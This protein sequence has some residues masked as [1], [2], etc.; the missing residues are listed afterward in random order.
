[1]VFQM[2]ND[3][4]ETDFMLETGF[5]N[6]ESF[7]SAWN[8]NAND[9]LKRKEHISV[10]G[11][12]IGEEEV[13]FLNIECD[14]DG[15]SIRWRDIGKGISLEYTHLTIAPRGQLDIRPIYSMVKKH[16]NLPKLGKISVANLKNVV[17]C[18]VMYYGGWET[19]LAYVPNI[20]NRTEYT[21]ELL[22]NITAANL[23]NFR[24]EFQK[25]LHGLLDKNVASD[26]LAKNN[27]MNLKKM[28]VLPA[29]R[30]IIL[31]VFQSSLEATDSVV[32]GMVPLLFSFRF[33]EKC[34]T[35]LLL[36]ILDESGVEDICVHV[37]IDIRNEF[38]DVLWCR[39]GVNAVVGNRGQI[40]SALS[41]FEC[42]NF[43]SNVDDR[44][45][46]VSKQL[47]EVCRFPEH[48]RFVQLYANTPHRRATL[49]PHS[50]SASILFAEGL[51]REPSYARLKRNTEEYIDEITNNF[52][53]LRGSTCRM[54]F[55]IALPVVVN[56]VFGT[57]YI[58]KDNLLQLL[59]DEPMIVPFE[60]SGN[61]FGCIRKVGIH[62]CAS[63][64]HLYRTRCRTGNSDAVWEAYQCELAVE[65]LLWGN[66]FCAKSRIYSVNLGVGL[67]YPSRCLTDQRG[68]LCLEESSACCIDEDTTPKLNIYTQNVTVQRQ[69][70]RVFGF[71][72]YTQAGSSVLGQ[73]LM[74][75]LIRDLY[76]VG[77]V[78]FRVEYFFLMLKKS[79]GNGNK[80]I[81]GGITIE[82]LAHK[83]A[84]CKKC[85]WPM[86]FA[87]L[88]KLLSNNFEKLKELCVE[89]VHALQLGYFPAV[90]ES[91]TSKHGGLNWNYMYG[92][93]VLMDNDTR[94]D[95]FETEASSIHTSVLC[96][97]EKW[98]ICH[99]SQYEQNVFP[100]I[101][102][103]L[104]KI[105]EKNLTREDKVVVLAFV[106]AVA[107]LMNDR[108][109][110]YS[111]LSRLEKKMP[112]T[113]FMLKMLEVQC[114]FLYG[115]VNTFRLHRLHPSIPYRLENRKA[116]SLLP[117]NE[118]QQDV[119]VDHV[120]DDNELGGMSAVDDED[121]GDQVE[122]VS[123]RHLPTSSNR[124][125]WSLGEVQILKEVAGEIRGT[126]VEQYKSYQEKCRCKGIPDRTYMAFIAKLSRILPRK[127]KST[128]KED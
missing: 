43:Q 38:N 6:T 26:T 71:H 44:E 87:T 70:T 100:W 30:Q 99:T 14:I 53:Q 97:L 90:R 68:F 122:I 5:E 9:F 46:N 19:W 41:F 93:W 45:I 95:S 84:N 62:L 112:I 31:S 120:R 81:V 128:D 36:P 37:G 125:M 119:H 47:L 42:V 4:N 126:R 51:L 1:M 24:I 88:K 65:R 109:V 86:V 118:K 104:E 66:P 50:V 102:T 114:K 121:I 20:T 25:Q 67:G 85:K 113:Q 59:K 15:V 3:V 75:I 22:R 12:A 57:D 82:D 110:D 83:L 21:T 32:P 80:K 89:G 17:G 10:R 94:S 76:E 35:P 55:V 61:V 52:K 23:N 56:K 40:T 101:K 60:K 18:Q 64:L 111:N 29:D 79:T 2:A 58:D 73:R 63:L 28:F 34:R 107:M 11:T 116:R 117:K 72:N 108:Y 105:A 106:S 127:R 39:E 69:L 13:E 103:V 124:L 16:F 91:D 54:E 123:S 77:R 98:K 78:F 92:F 27:L 96:E 74:R 33:G 48:V 49:V 8:E 7:K 115:N